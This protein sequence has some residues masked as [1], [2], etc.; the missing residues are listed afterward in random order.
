MRWLVWWWFESRTSRF[1]RA[2][3]KSGLK[4][5]VL[6]RAASSC[7]ALRNTRRGGTVVGKVV[8]GVGAMALRAVWRWSE[9]SALTVATRSIVSQ[10]RW[11]WRTN[12]MNEANPS[13]RAGIESLASKNCS[14]P[15]QLT[16]RICGCCGGLAGLAARLFLEHG[17][18]T[19]WRFWRGSLRPKWFRAREVNTRLQLHKNHKQAGGQALSKSIVRY[20]HLGLVS[21]IIGYCSKCRVL[22]ME[23]V[24][25]IVNT[26]CSATLPP[27]PPAFP[28]CPASSFCMQ[29][30]P[31]PLRP[32]AL[33]SS[34]DFP[35]P[36]V[37]FRRQPRHRE[38]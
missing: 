13:C 17:L 3:G 19:G 15:G 4:S 10:H 35:L 29:P 25:F 30:P 11:C 12:Q 33:L 16:P 32:E 8:F 37:L 28:F 26:D 7:A 36:L 34:S 31:P 5:M 6:R 14:V 18:I 27:A 20:E 1:F 9:L 21:C 23:W 2:D 38:P 22:Q 24:S